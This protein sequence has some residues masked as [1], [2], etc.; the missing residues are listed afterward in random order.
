MHSAELTGHAYVA[1]QALGALRAERDA[2]ALDRDT[3]KMRVATAEAQAKDAAIVASTL[4]EAKPV[5][6]AAERRVKKRRVK[7]RSRSK[8]RPTVRRRTKRSARTSK[9][10]KNLEG[11]LNS[12]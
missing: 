12:L 4:A 6:Q 5:E 8:R 3:L 2:L 7:R 10:D 9:T 11:L 1:Q